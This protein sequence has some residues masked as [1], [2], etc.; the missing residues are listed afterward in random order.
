MAFF[1]LEDRYHELECIAFPNKYAAYAPMITTDSAVI[2]EGSLQFREGESPKIL[3]NSVSPLTENEKFVSP[4]S[5]ESPPKKDVSPAD[6][7]ASAVPARPA[8]PPQKINKLYLRVPDMTSHL[9]KKVDNLV[10]IFDGWTPVI[11]FDS[12]QKQYIPSDHR[13]TLTPGC[14]TELIALVGAEN[15]VPK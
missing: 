15:V 2:I 4:P 9:F 7:P 11:Y 1:T 10:Q 14:Y 5:K 12:S 6:R 8:V 13:I 3:V